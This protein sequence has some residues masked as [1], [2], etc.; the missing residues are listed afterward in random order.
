MEQTEISIT[1]FLGLLFRFSTR[2]L[3]LEYHDTPSS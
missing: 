1:G 2:Q 3:L